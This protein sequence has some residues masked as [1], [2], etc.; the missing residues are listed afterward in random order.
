MSGKMARDGGSDSHPARGVTDVVRRGRTVTALALIAVLGAGVWTIFD[1]NRSPAHRIRDVSLLTVDR[2]FPAEGRY[3]LDPYI[4]HQVCAECHPRESALYARSGHSRTLRAAGQRSLAH[5]L[6][7]TKVADPEYSD[8]LWG[9]QYRDGQLHIS[10][11]AADKVEEF[12]AQYAFGSGHHATTFMT[13]IDPGIPRIFEHRLTYF[14][15]E[16]QLKLTPGHSARTRLSGVTPQ[17]GVLLAS[18]ARKCFG[19]HTTQT[20]ARAGLAIDEETL[21]PNVSCERCHGPGRAHVEAARR[22]APEAELALPFGVGRFTAESLL[23]LCGTCHRH[24]SRLDREKI[25]PDNP[26]MARFQPIGIL[27]SRCFRESGGA[28]NCV[29]CHDPHASAASDRASY[30]AVCLSCHAV[31]KPKPATPPTG[32]ET[33]RQDHPPPT[34][35]ACP[36]EPTGDC[37]NCHMPRVDAGQ[38]ILFA[39]HWIRVRRLGETASPA[40]A[41]AP[42][43]QLLDIPDP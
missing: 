28:F 12:V 14:T 13:V 6:D 31:N 30:L 34:A 11:T 20:S 7:G 4:G 16:E 10:R 21:I 35:E 43:V 23:V 9:Y 32:A 26:H 39:D 24:P 33:G 27:N 15:R 40:R 2:P 1:L 19:C 5:R 38:H 42:E 29:T 18:D 3:P 37:V 41:P 8:V 36:V 22:S 25:R 17:G